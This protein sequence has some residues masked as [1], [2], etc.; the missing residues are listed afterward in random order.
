MHENL[1]A[2]GTRVFVHAEAAPMTGTVAGYATLH[3]VLNIYAPTLP[4]RPMVLVHLDQQYTGYVGV[5]RGRIPG[6]GEIATH[7]SILTCSPDTVTP[8]ADIA[9]NPERPVL[10]MRPPTPPRPC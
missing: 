10:R 7:V 3:G 1:P 5:E 9:T 4:V 2:I 6:Y 8:I